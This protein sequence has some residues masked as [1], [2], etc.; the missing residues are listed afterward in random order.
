MTIQP[1]L[2]KGLWVGFSIFMAVALTTA[3]QSTK[4]QSPNIAAV[5][6]REE[7]YWKLVKAGDVENYRALWD[8]NFRGWPCKNQQTATKSEI[9]N[10][11]R[12]IRNQKPKFTYSLSFDGAADFGDVVVIYYKTPMIYEY[13]DG[14]VVDKEKLF[15]FTHTWRKA[16]ATWLIIGGMCG[17]ILSPSSGN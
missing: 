2:R 9:G 17:E 16:G 7:L 3:Q 12:D 6:K 8:E 14:R 5:W 4:S 15:K 13:S 11:V 10:W 1:L